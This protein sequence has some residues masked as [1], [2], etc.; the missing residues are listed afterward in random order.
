MQPETIP[1]TRDEEAQLEPLRVD[2]PFVEWVDSSTHFARLR[3]LRW[4]VQRGDLGGSRDGS[5]FPT[6]AFDSWV[7]EV[8]GQ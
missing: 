2:Y 1:L 5:T 7:E 6:E 4:R 3:F 8:Y